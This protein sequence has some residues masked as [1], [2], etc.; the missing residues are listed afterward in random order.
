M[1]VAAAGIGP[2]LQA[3]LRFGQISIGRGEKELAA[4]LSEVGHHLKRLAVKQRH[5]PWK[6]S[7][8]VEIYIVK[9]R[10]LFQVDS[11]YNYNMLQL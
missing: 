8:S 2:I 11:K 9:T 6:E 5:S 1:F 4:G 7:M 3:A 10:S